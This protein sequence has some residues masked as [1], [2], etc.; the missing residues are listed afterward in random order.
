[1]V[2]TLPRHRPRGCPRDRVNAE[3]SPALFAFSSSGRWLRFSVSAAPPVAPGPICPVRCAEWCEDRA[4][5]ALFCS[6]I[7]Q[8]TWTALKFAA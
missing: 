7:S 8:C 5:R 1:M 4:S 2:Q 3:P 6:Q